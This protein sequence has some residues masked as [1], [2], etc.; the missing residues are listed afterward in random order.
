V[1]C[2][3]DTVEQVY[4]YVARR[5]ADDRINQPIGIDEAASTSEPL[6]RVLDEA[7]AI[8]AVSGQTTLG[9]PCALRLALTSNAKN[10]R[11]RSVAADDRDATYSQTGR[12]GELCDNFGPAVP[13]L[14]AG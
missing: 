5:R 2:A 12:V 4:G 6:V 8:E 3:G 10:A 1:R 9:P 7:V 13:T 11:T 14:R